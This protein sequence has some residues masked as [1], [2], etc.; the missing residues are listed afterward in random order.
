VKLIAEPWDLGDGGYQV[1]NF[2][3]LWSEWNGRYRD[4]VRD[5]WRGEPARLADFGYRLTGS[6]DLY[7]QDGRRPVASINLV[8]VHDG[9]TLADL[10]SFN[11]KHNEANGE[12]NRDGENHNRSWNCGVEGP[13]DDP[14]VVALRRR[15]QRNLLATLMLSQGVPHLLGGDE[16][17]RTQQ[18]N[19]NAY[20][21]DNEISWFDWSLAEENEWLVSFTAA[22][23][24]LRREHPILR[25]RRWFHGRPI[26]GT[27]DIAWFTPSGEEMSDDDWGA[28]F[29]KSVAVY[30]DGGAIP[31][32][33]RRGQRV[34]DDCFLLV[35]NASDETIE[36]TVPREIGSGWRLILDTSSDDP[37]SSELGETFKV[38]DRSTVILMRPLHGPKDG[39]AHA[40]DE[41]L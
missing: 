18:G 39:A 34:T 35:F 17:G 36:W 10:V 21:Q 26:R 23:I 41:H 27:P 3:V 15:Q 16:M 38:T 31:D 40:T 29:A 13:T 19:N 8:T 4:T 24:E 7:E 30:L 9:F 25:R 33:D 6:S 37:Q 28:G 1:G 2:P 14:G 12:D 11:E 32:V 5:F 22:M 20:C